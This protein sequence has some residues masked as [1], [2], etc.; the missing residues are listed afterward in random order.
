MTAKERMKCLFLN[1]P[2]DRVPYS[3][4]FNGYLAISNGVTLYDFYTNPDRAFQAGMESMKKYAW[5][6][7][8]P[9]YGWG[10]HGAWEFGGKIGWPESDR[11]MTP[12][13]VEAL[14][15]KPE[16]VDE[17][18]DPDPTKTEWFRLRNHFNEIC[19]QNGFSAA[20]PSASIAT[21][22]G[23]IVGTENLMKWI[24]KYPEAVHRLAE[25]VLRFNMKM[26]QIMLE[27]YGAKHCNVFT[28]LPSE[29]NNI[30]SPE[31][32]E[33][34]CLPYI[35]RLQALYLERGVRSIMIHMCGDH[36]KNL[37]YWKRVPLPERTVFS[38]GDNMELKKTG[39]FLGEKYILAGNIST[40]VLQ[41]GT[42]EEIK[43]EVRRCLR[44]GKGRKGGFIL[45]PACEYPPM[46]P[47]ENLDIIRE[48]LMEYG[49]Y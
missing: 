6:S 32:F 46:A 28:D 48:T 1:K 29:S 30:M 5:T 33:E 34:F 42:R 41:L 10:D 13:S 18:P 19:I 24:I 44:Q 17:L 39:D 38:I 27:K 9:V 40:T 35:V 12:Y 49:F 25:K 22:M 31:A 14:I 3:P 15:T 11:T 47:P 43:E 45:S 23:S 4:F 16:E 7:M 37:K 36:N 26:A 20:L 21:P 2:I 8:R